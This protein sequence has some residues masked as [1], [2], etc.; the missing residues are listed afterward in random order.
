M[1]AAEIRMQPVMRARAME[2]ANIMMM[3]TMIARKEISRRQGDI[4]DDDNDDID[5]DDDDNDD[6]NEEISIQLM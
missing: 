5:D 6:D 3:S 4:K 1:E 2:T